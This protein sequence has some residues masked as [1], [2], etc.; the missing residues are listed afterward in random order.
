MKGYELLL[1]AFTPI[2]V[3]GQLLAR[4]RSQILLS[5]GVIIAKSYRGRISYNQPI[6]TLSKLKSL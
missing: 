6:V 5:N 2:A 4:Q 1:A 3:S